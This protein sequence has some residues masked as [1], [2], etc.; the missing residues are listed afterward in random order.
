MR[1]STSNFPPR[2]RWRGRIRCWKR[3]RGF[4]GK[5]EGVK[6]Y[7][8]IGGFSLLTRTSASYQGFFFTGLKP[9]MSARRRISRRRELSRA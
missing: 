5:T 1:S 4:L 8:T 2:P 7:T 9:W 6:Y 3:S